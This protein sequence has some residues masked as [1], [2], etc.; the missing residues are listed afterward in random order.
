M[1]TSA[2]FILALGAIS[3]AIIANIILASDKQNNDDL[4]SD[5]DIKTE[6]PDTEAK[7]NPYIGTSD[8]IQAST[9]VTMHNS[10]T[11]NEPVQEIKEESAAQTN[12]IKDNLKVM[13]WIYPGEPACLAAKE[14]ADGRK[15]NV[16]KPEFF[17]I[18]GG[19]L[20]LLNTQNS[21]C[22]SYS[23]S[24][25]RLIKKYSDEQYVTVSSSNTDD[26]RLFFKS[27]L[28]LAVKTLSQF[29]IDNKLTGIELDFEDFGSW[30]SEDYTNYLEFV[31]KLGNALDKSEK[32]LMLDAPA[33]SSNTEQGWFKWKYEDFIN[34][35]VDYIVVMTYDYQFDHGAGSAVA[36]INWI[37]S[38]LNYASSRYPKEKLVAGIPSYGYEAASNKRP[39]I[40]TYDQLKNKAGFNQAKRDPDSGEMFWKYN[41]TYYF[42]QD[43]ESI[44]QKIQAVQSLGIDKISIWHLGGNNWF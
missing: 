10:Q 37:K 6:S 2:W 38:S 33:I 12:I 9:T 11:T 32:K 17:T 20:K 23:E 25:V 21:G 43:K 27:D 13:A 40:R 1:K 26:M 35:P 16:I 7:D 31:T 22:N 28:D 3:I 24:T 19:S 44:Y 5:F 39:L 29:V 42:Y 4:S 30:S 8:L 36:P 14:I 34:L 41:N 18:N 15:I